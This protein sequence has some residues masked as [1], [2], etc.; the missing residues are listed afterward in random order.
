[1]RVSVERDGKTIQLNSYSLLQDGFFEHMRE[2]GFD[3]FERGE[4]GSNREHLSDLDFK[5]Q[6]DK[7]RLAEKQEQLASADVE[8]TSTHEQISEAN[9]QLNTLNQNIKSAE[10]KILNRKQIE[11]IP[12]KIS[13]PMFGGGDEVTVSKK[14]WDSVKKTAL[15]QAKT[16][17]EYQLAISQRNALKAEKRKLQVE[18][19]GLENKIAELTNNA[20]KDFMERA[21]KYAELHN[22][23]NDVA[24]IPSDIW[25]AY[26][27]QSTQQ[28]NHTQEVQ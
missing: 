24:K 12:V 15:T 8:L 20:S 4:R 9:K 6:Q 21:T 7:K 5:I 22:L 11:K 26:T 14:D 19:L 23:K 17:E 1:M 25:N 18:K 3:G 10:G 2:S 13:R 16:D 27:K 28:K